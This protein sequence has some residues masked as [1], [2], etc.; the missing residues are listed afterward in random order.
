M[1]NLR[2]FLTLVISGGNRM[3]LQNEFIICIIR[4]NMKQDIKNMEEDMSEILNGWTKSMLEKM[5]L[6]VFL[7]IV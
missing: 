6:F 4:I 2:Y 7:Q 5:N 1:P 3:I